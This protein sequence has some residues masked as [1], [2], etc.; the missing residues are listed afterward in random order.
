[1]QK[2]LISSTIRSLDEAPTVCGGMPW[3]D[4]RT[5]DDSSGGGALTFVVAL[6]EILF[7]E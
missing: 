3:Y 2:Y 1:M 7:L 5:K 6:G 4:E